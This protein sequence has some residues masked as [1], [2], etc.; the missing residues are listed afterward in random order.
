MLQDS[1]SKSKRMIT[2]KAKA[3][4]IIASKMK[5]VAAP[6]LSCHRQLGEISNHYQL[7][8]KVETIAALAS[9]SLVLKP[10]KVE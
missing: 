2:G 9:K 6:C 7:G 5:Y 3:D 10:K 4:Q 1:T 8:V